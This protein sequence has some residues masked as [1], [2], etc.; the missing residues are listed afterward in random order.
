MAGNNDE[1]LATLKEYAEFWK[2]P[3]T[4]ESR[5]DQK[6]FLLTS[7][8]GVFD[9]IGSNSVIISP[10][11]V[12]DAKGIA[13]RFG[14]GLISKEAKVRLRVSPG[15]SVSLTAILHQY[16]GP[17][18]EGRLDDGHNTL[19]YGIKGSNVHILSVDL[20]SEY[21]RLLHER[22]DEDANWKFR[23]VTRMPLSYSLIPSSIRKRAFK[24]KRDLASV[25]GEMYGPV[26]CLR[27]IFLASLVVASPNPIPIIRFWRR[28]KSYALAI[29]HDV[30]T[31]MGLE[32]GA[33]RLIE[34]EKELDIRSTWNIPSDRYPLS[35][36]L[37]VSLAKNGEV[38]AHDTR[39][40][41][42]LLFTKGE[43][44]VQRVRR[45]K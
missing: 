12:D 13:K 34:V 22:V 5:A 30:E 25:P 40:D 15:A 39:H 19:L 29:S 11:G 33:A 21:R 6:N 38:G 45:F 42:K 2:V 35:S 44:K 17:N 27:S 41:G 23:L 10:I 31:Q 1:E 32:D 28:G 8:L 4:L 7:N 24:T 20:I 36:Q 3:F 37:L 9:D 14:L 43:A 26:E 18:L 16:S